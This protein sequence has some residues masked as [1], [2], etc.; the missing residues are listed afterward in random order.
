MTEYR[1]Q[2]TLQSQHTDRVGT[3]GSAYDK[4]RQAAREFFQARVPA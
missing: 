3:D 1:H 4:V 2:E